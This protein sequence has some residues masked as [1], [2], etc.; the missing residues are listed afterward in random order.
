MLPLQSAEWNDDDEDD[1]FEYDCV[2]LSLTSSMPCDFTE[3][4]FRES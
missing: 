2:Y 3:F 4:Q 1:N